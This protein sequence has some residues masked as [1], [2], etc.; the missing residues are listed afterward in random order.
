MMEID[1][2]IILFVFGVWEPAFLIA[3]LERGVWL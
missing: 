3:H 1:W 2:F